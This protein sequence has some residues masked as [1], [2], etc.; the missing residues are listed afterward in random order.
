MCVCVFD[1]HLFHS[2][3][4]RHPFGLNLIQRDVFVRQIK[5]THTLAIARKTL[6]T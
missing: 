5:S 4:G 6:E 3:I 1:C 2:I